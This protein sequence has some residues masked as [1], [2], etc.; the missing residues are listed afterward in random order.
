VGKVI[1]R[2][3][4]KASG[5]S[6]FGA[7][8]VAMFATAGVCALLLSGAATNSFTFE[9]SAAQTQ[10]PAREVTDAAASG[11]KY[12][13]FVRTPGP[14]CDGVALTPPVTSNPDYIQDAVASHAENTVFCLGSGT[15]HNQ[16]VVP[17]NGQKFVGVGTVILSGAK[18]ITQSPVN[19]WRQ[20]GTSNRWYLSGQNQGLE[21][22]ISCSSGNNQDASRK[23]RYSEDVLVTSSGQTTA[24]IHQERIQDV[25]S[26][27]EMYFDYETDRIYIGAN[28]SSFN[29]IET[30]LT[31]RAFSGN[32]DNI[33]IKN[34]TV[35]K[36]ANQASSGAIQASGD[37]NNPPINWLLDGVTARLNHG[38]GISFGNARNS[39]ITCTRVLTSGERDTCTKVYSNG[40]I[41]IKLNASSDTEVSYAEIYKN[42]TLG[43]LPG[44]EGGGLKLGESHDILVKNNISHSNAGTGLWSDAE[45][46]NIEFAN[47]SVYSNERAGIFHE[48][49]F[50]AKIHDNIVWRNGF[51][52]AFCFGAGIQIAASEG[53]SLN[54]I[55][56]YNNK[57]I[58]NLNSIMGIQQDRSKIV[59]GATVV[60]YL[61]YMD[62]Y[63]NQIISTDIPRPTSVA[64][65][66]TG[67][68]TDN[69]TVAPD[70]FTALASN[71]FR[72]NVYCG[73][74]NEW[75][76]KKAGTLGSGSIG[77]SAWQV[78]WPNE[79]LGTLTSS[80]EEKSWSCT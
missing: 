48:I 55:Q 11:G 35:E 43:F 77:L 25:E 66:K 69:P 22:R 75:W 59:D 20:D 18:D 53:T 19:N 47:N 44:W 79:R 33:V 61:R 6:G 16:S 37:D 80:G 3:T 71:T 64:N 2:L 68:C 21:P 8:F 7:A 27:T 72:N 36:Y 60:R 56:I 67:V 39:K 32:A 73:T 70:P 38:A 63:S 14:A 49:G 31:Q 76:W 58:N 46:R 12:I 41:G 52:H 17:K 40:Q 62:V 30:S 10:G 9:P 34:I 57:L 4:R 28:P 24:L 13:E 65:A 45:S 78:L 1:Q 29:K 5:R 23:C 42:N 51:R 26:A 15:Y 54:K 50:S 74:K